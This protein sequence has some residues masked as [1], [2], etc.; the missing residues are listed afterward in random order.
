MISAN[1]V[2][3]SFFLSCMSEQWKKIRRE[4]KKAF[5]EKQFSD[6]L[7]HDALIKVHKKIT[8][9]GFNNPS[10]HTFKSYLFLS[11]RNEVFM[12][13]NKQSNGWIDFVDELPEIEY[14]QESE[15]WNQANQRIDDAFKNEIY[16]YVISKY[17]HLDS[18]LFQF[19]YKNQKLSY[20]QIEQMTGFKIGYV[21]NRIKVMK[22]DVYKKFGNIDRR[23]LSDIL[24]D[25]FFE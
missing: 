24:T 16:S 17:D 9:S 8:K 6:E 4:F 7:L 5:N 19:Y 2:I 13:K 15:Q 18:E 22:K 25:N 21:F 23:R 10:S 11:Y 14:D 3:A 1:T 20:E 12:E